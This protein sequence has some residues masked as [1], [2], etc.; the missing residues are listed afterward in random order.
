MIRS[1]VL[2]VVLSA[3]TSFAQDNVSRMDKLLQQYHENRG[4][5]GTVIVAEDGAITYAK[6]F[7]LADREK[8]IPNG[9]KIHYRI[10]SITK[11]FTATLI[12]KLA[13]Q[14]KLNVQD[15]ISR[16]LPDYRKDVA[17]KVTI[18]HLLTHSSG[19]PNYV[20]S[21]EW[22][23][24]VAQPMPSLD[25][26]IRTYCS[27]DLEFEPGS[28]FTY[29]NSGYVLLGAIIAHVTGMTYEDAL[30]TMILEPAGMKDTGLDCAGLE[31]P[32]RAQ[33]YVA[34]YAEEPD[35]A[36]PWN[37][38]WAYSAGAMYSTP[39]DMVKWDQ[40]LYD[41]AMITK[42]SLRLMSTPYF[43]AFQPGSKYGYGFTLSRRVKARNGDSVLVMSHE[44]GL[45]GF[46]S[47]FSRVLAN[48]QMV[49]VASNTSDAPLLAITQGIFEIVNGYEATPPARSL[50][51]ELYA[52]IKSEGLQGGLRN[53][54]SKLYSNR[55]SLLI[56]ENELNTLGY[57]FL[58]QNKLAEAEAV[59]SLNVRE[60]PKS[61]NVYD[62][63]GEC[64]AAMGQKE[65][66]ITLY[67]KSLA[68][69]PNN[70]SGAEA[71]KKMGAE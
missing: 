41:N 9:P 63:L 34:G 44:G 25:H 13:E 60:F 51:C 54:Q 42:P 19:I 6:G 5:V 67:K 69:N 10:A 18:H 46:N 55:S 61:W 15:P 16:Y 45:P 62:S 24:Q 32:G 47:L 8:N 64:Y 26:L 40:A 30:R 12:M 71:L 36:D 17:D 35:K 38:D 11:T 50:A 27:G 14:G 43:P 56:N 31:I 59:F 48:H 53:V 66:A 49:F 7:G 21:E 1:F 22:R 3:V 20:N 58:R 37:I 39:E 52:S 57:S 28:K 2:A 4:F 70:T 29:S 33:G 68:L 65:K 23:K